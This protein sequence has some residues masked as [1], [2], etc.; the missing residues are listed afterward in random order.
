MKLLI[1]GAGGYGQLVKEIAE[2]TEQFER[3]DFLD[4]NYKDAVGKIADLKAK[5]NDY[6]GCIVAIGNPVIREKLFSVIENPVSMIHPKAVISKS[7]VIGGGCVVEAN[8]VVNTNAI[9]KEASYICAGSVINHDAYVSEFC[10]VDCNAVI[11]AGSHL[12]KGSK[13]DSGTV[14]NSK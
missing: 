14:F 6:D 7:A 13:V 10:Q 9:I 3:I 1:V 4:D 12:P 5:Q 2:L 8:A 11:S